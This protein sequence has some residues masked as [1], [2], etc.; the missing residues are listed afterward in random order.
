MGKSMGAPYG[1]RGVPVGN[2][3]SSSTYSTGDGVGW[4]K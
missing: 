3:H 2:G 4:V 1:A